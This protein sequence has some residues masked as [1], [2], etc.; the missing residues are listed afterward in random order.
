MSVTG[1]NHVNIRTLNI[2]ETVGFYTEVLGL[3]YDGP[4]MVGGFTRNWLRDQ[5]GQPIIHLR[6]LAP[7]S[8]STGAI[9]HI[10]LSCVDM[11]GVLGRLKA[12]GIQFASRDNPIDGIVQVVFTD[13]NGITIELNFPLA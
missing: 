10:A 1:V 9:D 3:R 11:H 5:G 8:M 13:P 6:E 7:P 12:K 4:K 2:A